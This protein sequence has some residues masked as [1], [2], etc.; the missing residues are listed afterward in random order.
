MSECMHVRMLTGVDTGVK[1]LVPLAQGLVFYSES[2]SHHIF[3]RRELRSYL[4]FI[5]NTCV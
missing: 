2:S 4:Y 5:K 3:Q 1:C